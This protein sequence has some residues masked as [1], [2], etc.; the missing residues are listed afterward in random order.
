MPTQTLIP[1]HTYN[2]RYVRRT[3]HGS[4]TFQY[5]FNTFKPIVIVITTHTYTHYMHT[6]TY[7]QWTFTKVYHTNTRIHSPPHI[8]SK[9]FNIYV[10]CTVYSVQCIPSYTYINIYIPVY[11]YISSLSTQTSFIYDNIP[12]IHHQTQIHRNTN[13][14]NNNSLCNNYKNQ[15]IWSK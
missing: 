4:H 7:M 3:Y 5:I 15:F 10:Q 11:K 6:S 9:Q 2:V 13:T 1:S 12:S 14:H 8:H